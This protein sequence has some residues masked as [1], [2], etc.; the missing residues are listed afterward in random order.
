[1]FLICT[2]NMKSRQ[3]T[4]VSLARTWEFARRKALQVQDKVG[5]EDQSVIYFVTKKEGAVRIT[6]V[7]GGETANSLAQW[8]AT[9]QVVQRLLQENPIRYGDLKWQPHQ[10]FAFRLLKEDPEA[11]DLWH[12]VVAR[13]G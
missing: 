12:D 5:G 10:E 6:R 2:E 4:P 1:M 8:P 9:A 11:M 7:Y 3:L 13:G